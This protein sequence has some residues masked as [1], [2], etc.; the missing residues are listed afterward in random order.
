MNFF[1]V[2]CLVFTTNSPVIEWHS[3]KHKLNKETARKGVGWGEGCNFQPS[4]SLTMLSQHTVLHK[5]RL[6][7][8]VG[9]LQV[10]HMTG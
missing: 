4:A 9:Q 5:N 2:C 7:V 10:K 6:G 3:L 1:C 8:Y